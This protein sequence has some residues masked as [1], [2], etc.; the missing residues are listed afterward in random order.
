MVKRLTEKLE[1][2]RSVKDVKHRSTTRGLKQNTKKVS[3]SVVE[4]PETSTRYHVQ[5][6][7]ISTATSQ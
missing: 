4:N 2:P 7:N 3:E 1:N 5:K 6:F